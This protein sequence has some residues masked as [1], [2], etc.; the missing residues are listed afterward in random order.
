MFRYEAE[1]PG[2]GTMQV[3][4]ADHYTEGFQKIDSQIIHIITFVVVDTVV[5]DPDMPR[6]LRKPAYYRHRAVATIRNPAYV[7]E[8]CY[9]ASQGI[10]HEV[11][12]GGQVLNGGNHES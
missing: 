4:W 5:V 1:V 12:E 3:V 6:N 10:R 8:V 9:D 7:R 2:V 11:N